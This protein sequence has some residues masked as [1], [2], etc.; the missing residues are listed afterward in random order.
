MD[1]LNPGKGSN[2]HGKEEVVDVDTGD[3]PDALGSG[4]GALLERFRH[5]SSAN[6]HRASN[7][8]STDQGYPSADF[9]E[10]KDT[11]DLTENSHCVV[12]AVD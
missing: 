6:E 11:H 5:N 4:A 1:L 8:V 10:E 2:A 3:E 9:V 12:D 7:Y